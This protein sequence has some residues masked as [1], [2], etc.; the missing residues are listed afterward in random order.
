M[1]DDLIMCVE[2]GTMFSV[3]DADN[4]SPSTSSVA[5]PECGRHNYCDSIDMGGYHVDSV[6]D[7][8][9]E[10]TDEIYTEGYLS[11]DLEYDGE[12][13]F[14]KKKQTRIGVAKQKRS[15]PRM[16]FYETRKTIASLLAS[17]DENTLSASQRKEMESL[18]RDDYDNEEEFE[19]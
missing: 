16:P 19:Q 1:E 11:D 9:L 6:F 13:R 2:C 4:V 5:C 8:G 15:M 18:I 14:E 10:E 12:N 3:D 7:D 17:S